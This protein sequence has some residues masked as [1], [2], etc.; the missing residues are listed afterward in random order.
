MPRG[1]ESAIVIGWTRESETETAFLPR[2][3]TLK[4]GDCQNMEMKALSVSDYISEGLYCDYRPIRGRCVRWQFAGY[5]GIVQMIHQRKAG[6]SVC[7]NR[8]DN[9]ILDCAP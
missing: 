1:W 7:S 5:P 9:C 3:W 8:L 6:S 4:V 2:H